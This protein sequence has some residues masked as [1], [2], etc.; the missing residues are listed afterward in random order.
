MTTVTQQNVNELI[1]WL[2]EKRPAIAPYSFTEGKKYFKIIHSSTSA[3]CFIAKSDFTN[4][5]MGMVKAGHIYKPSGYS[6]P[7]K[8]ARGNLL[9][10]DTW[11]RCFDKY[12]VVYR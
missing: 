12:G 1:T 9:D 8:H 7:A 2:T 11:D 5:Q 4:K 10:R 6:T 3:Y